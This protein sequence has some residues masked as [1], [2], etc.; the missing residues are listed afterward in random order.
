M[1]D[2]LAHHAGLIGLLLFFIF[3]LIIAFWAFRPSKKAE[4]QA[5]AHI[6][7]KEN[8]HDR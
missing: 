7:L 3:F 6:P 5:H 4:L 1:I 8:P 2:F